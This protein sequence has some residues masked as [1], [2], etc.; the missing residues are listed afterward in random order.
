ML[1]RYPYPILAARLSLP[2]VILSEAKNLASR[3]HGQRGHD[4]A[5]VWDRGARAGLASPHPAPL[6][7]GEREQGL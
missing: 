5:G 2:I 6:P 4:V 1:L 7:Q 3:L